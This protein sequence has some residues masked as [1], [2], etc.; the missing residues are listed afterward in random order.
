MGGLSTKRT[1]FGG[2]LELNV[3]D[4]MLGAS[5]NERVKNSKELSRWAPGL[6]SSLAQSLMKNV[7]NKVV[8]KQKVLTGAEHV[9]LIGHVPYRRDCRVCQETLQQC[10]PHRK[11]KKVIGGVLSVDVAGPM[12]P[13]YD[14]GGKQARWL[15]VGVLTWRVP[16]GTEKMKPEEDQPAPEDSPK[17]E[18]G[19]REVPSADSEVQEEQREELCGDED[20]EPKD[21]N[22]ERSGEDKAEEIE[23]VK[24]GGGDIV[25]G[26]TGSRRDRAAVL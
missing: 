20:L 22:Q 8:S 2:S 14:M 6:M 11:V 13:A 23:E 12:V 1:T 18:A 21:E 25:P 15:L 16:K 17:I 7:F 5:R 10:A 24:E 26:R 4:F 3:E 9:A 19:A